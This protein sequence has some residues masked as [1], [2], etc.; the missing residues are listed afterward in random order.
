MDKNILVTRPTRAWIVFLSRTTPGASHDKRVLDEAA[1]RFPTHTVLETD[2]AF[3]GYTAANLH[4]IHPK[5][6][7][8][9][10]AC[11]TLDRIAN[12]LKASARVAV[13]H[14]LA[15]VKR[16]QILSSVLRNLTDGFSDRVMEIGCGL[17]NL[18]TAF[19]QPHRMTAEI[20]SQ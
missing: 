15:S 16:L 1:L 4:L 17:H 6:A 7:P 18:R 11:S 14:I 12:R 8:K 20:Y 2:T 10:R 19:R 3:L 5:R 13:E 9:G